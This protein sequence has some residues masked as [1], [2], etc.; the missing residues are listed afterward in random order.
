[1]IEE[2]ADVFNYCL[3]MA[4][5]LDVDIIKATSDKIDKNSEKYPVRLA[6]GS[7]AKYTE[8]SR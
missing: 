1:M 6:R 2:L 3:L 7:A 4:N 8:L 5:A